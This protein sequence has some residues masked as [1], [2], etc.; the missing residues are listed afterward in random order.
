MTTCLPALDAPARIREDI[1]KH[2]RRNLLHT[3][4]GLVELAADDWAAVTDRVDEPLVR[5]LLVGK[6]V[7]AAAQGVQLS[8][9][10]TSRLGR[11]PERPDALIA[12]LGNLIDNA[13]DALL[14]CRPPTG[15]G[16]RIEVDL[17]E[18]D[19]VTEVRVADNGPGVPL[20]KRQWIFVEGASTKQPG[21]GRHRG[22]GLA[23]VAG[24]VRERGG[25]VTVTGPHC[26]GAV[27]TVRLPRTVYAGGREAS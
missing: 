24:L 20:E 8:V 1:T 27:F 17:C 25:T 26:G 3:L 18:R 21:D 10:G 11:G 7:T 22:L 6:T 23:L 19:T 15:D 13:V 16:R 12:I 9:S 2:E 4:V 14:E 5:A